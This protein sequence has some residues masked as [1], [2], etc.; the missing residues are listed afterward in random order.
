MFRL[1][2]K[3]RTLLAHPTFLVHV[4]DKC[5]EQPGEMSPRDNH[6][7]NKTKLWNTHNRQIAGRTS[8]GFTSSMDGCFSLH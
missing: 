1:V 8:K 2:G 5:T 4:N 6:G 3:G 7:N